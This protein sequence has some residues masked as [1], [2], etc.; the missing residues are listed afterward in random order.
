MATRIS[1]TKAVTARMDITTVG[2]RLYLPKHDYDFTK[3]VC[4]SDLMKYYENGKQ[5]S[6]TGVDI[7]NLNLFLRV[8]DKADVHV[9]ISRDA[10][11]EALI[12]VLPHGEPV[13]IVRNVRRLGQPG[14]AFQNRYQL[15]KGIEGMYKRALSL[16]V[17]GSFLFMASFLC[18]PPGTATHRRPSAS[19]CRFP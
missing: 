14:Q 7:S 1:A 10:V 15:E 4:Q 3:L 11:H 17:T 2:A 12:A 5:V 8:I 19:T 6:Y 18:V 16:L 9:H 13:R